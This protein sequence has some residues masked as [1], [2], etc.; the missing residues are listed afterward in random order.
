M[1]GE[2]LKRN[3]SLIILKYLEPLHYSNCIFSTI[4]FQ[5]QISYSLSSQISS[6]LFIYGKYDKA[7]F[8]A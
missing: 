1:S 3:Q 5:H 8:Y 4:K 2:L 7:I 6:I